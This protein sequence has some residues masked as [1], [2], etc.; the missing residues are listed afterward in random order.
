VLICAHTVPQIADLVIKFDPQYVLLKDV[1]MHWNDEEIADFMD[2]IVPLVHG[3][4][5]VSH[6]YKYFRKPEMNEWPRKLDRY[7]WA[8]VPETH[9][10]MVKH[11]FK[12]VK[13]YPK[14][15]YKLISVRTPS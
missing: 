6:N 10:S 14:G 3:T 4:I 15:K 5:I 2:N 11:G 8:P 12:G 7:S 9:P 13:F 1:L